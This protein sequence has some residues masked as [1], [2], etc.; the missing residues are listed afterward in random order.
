MA[1]VWNLPIRSFS[2]GQPQTNNL[3]VKSDQLPRG[4]NVFAFASLSQM[5]TSAPANPAHTPWASIGIHTYAVWN[6]DG[7]V[8]P[9]IQPQGL[10][11]SLFIENIAWIEVMLE[12]RECDAIGNLTL[13]EWN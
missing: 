7:T 5:N 8:G 3:T 1:K 10:P 9:Q 12:A 2:H 13:I 11:S 6:D 4:L